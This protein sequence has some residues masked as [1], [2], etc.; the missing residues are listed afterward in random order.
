M[1]QEF[2]LLLIA[3]VDN[4]VFR[5][6]IHHF[7][8]KTFCCRD[9]NR[10]FWVWQ[11][12]GIDDKLTGLFTGLR[13]DMAKEFGAVRNEMGGGFEE[14]IRAALIV[15]RGISINTN[16]ASICLKKMGVVGLESPLKY[17]KMEA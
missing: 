9:G 6:H 17:V 8:E 5:K 16:F 10:G 1:P 13:E 3:S 4:D 12:A 14:E 2:N 15:L 11:L 7:Y